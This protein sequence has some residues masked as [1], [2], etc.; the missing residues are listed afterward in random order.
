MSSSSVCVYVY[1]CVLKTER[2]RGGKEG[3]EMHHLH[4]YSSINKTYFFFFLLS[5]FPFLL[6]ENSVIYEEKSL[7]RSQFIKELN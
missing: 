6:D 5:F 4:R 7:N 1:M 2:E 3:V